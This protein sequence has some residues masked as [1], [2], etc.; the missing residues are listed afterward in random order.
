MKASIKANGTGTWDSRR[1]TSR[2]L[3][4]AESGRGVARHHDRWVGGYQLEGGATL[5]F[6]VRFPTAELRHFPLGGSDEKKVAWLT[7]APEPGAVEVALLYF[8]PEARPV[9]HGDSGSTWLVHEGRLPDS[10]RV[11][12]VSRTVPVTP[13]APEA[14]REIAEQ[15]RAAG[16][17]P[18]AM[19]DGV[20]LLLRNGSPRNCCSRAGDERNAVPVSV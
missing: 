11:W 8:P 14:L 9:F 3:S 12:L 7:P 19:N 20:R 10:R 4:L 5:E 18:S 1:S 17:A 6:L 13:L 2:R 16:V 15:A